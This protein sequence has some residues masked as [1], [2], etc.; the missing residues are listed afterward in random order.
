MYKT[1]R[2]SKF[3]SNDSSLLQ[4][5]A[6][7]FDIGGTWFRSGVFTS[8]GELEC[9]TRQPACNYRN[10][11]HSTVA[12]LQEALVSY[13]VHETQRL[14][15][16]FPQENFQLVGI[17]MGAALNAHTGFI[18]GSGPLWG[19][20][21]APFDLLDSLQK[22]EPLMNWTIINDVTAALLWCVS[23]IDS[24][25]ISK[26]V[27]V[28]VSTGV[29]C[30][31]YSQI[32]QNIPVDRIHGLQGEIGH[33]PI[34]FK[35][36]EHPI[37]LSC[38]CGGLNHLNAFCSGRGIEKLLPLLA[39]MWTRD[40]QLSLL[41]TFNSNPASLTFRDFAEAIKRG[42][43][44]AI[45]IL[46]AVTL[47]LAEALIYLFTFDPE[48]EYLL[49]TGGVVRSLGTAYFHSLLNH[50]EKIGLY[51]ITEN[52]SSFFNRRI[53]LDTNGEDSG[54][55]GAAIAAQLQILSSPS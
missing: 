44:F 55:F 15:T 35:Y 6:V 48:V 34:D 28:T 12:E 7:V 37:K 10:T 54:L 29:G 16:A 49:L 38:D 30:R 42:D 8:S 41:H 17:S 27:V 4:A 45:S 3:T 46:D 31:T 40:F 20:E 53:H 26:S 23:E 9:V 52:D 11:F 13:L 36:R 51:Q 24:S 18:L 39:T 2:L 43:E 33:V 22:R 19:S 32:L 1:S 25:E 21:S 50:L 5:K 14:C 47:P